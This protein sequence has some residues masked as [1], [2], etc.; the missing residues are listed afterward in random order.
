MK[1]RHLI[2]L[3]QE[4]YSTIEVI[5]NAG[6]TRTYT[7][8]AWNKDK[9]EVGSQVIVDSPSKGL[10]V[11]EVVAVHLSPKIDLDAPWTYK[12]IVQKVDR[13]AYDEQL[14]REAQF[15]TA[16]LEVERVR[17]RELLLD[18]FRNAFPEGSMARAVFND[19]V[20]GIGASVVIQ[21][22]HDEQ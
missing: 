22:Q 18:Q 5:F 17:Q 11:V 1:N 10:V 7:Y 6:D 4:G 8:K 16:M 3:L 20:K 15:E 14:E 19:A 12:W 9:V 13:T 2:A 21:E